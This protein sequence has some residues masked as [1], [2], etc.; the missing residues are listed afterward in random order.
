MPAYLHP[1]ILLLF[2]GLEEFFKNVD[3]VTE[4]IISILKNEFKSSI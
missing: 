2:R 3:A 4:K 1:V